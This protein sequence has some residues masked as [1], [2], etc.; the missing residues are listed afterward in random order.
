ME[1]WAG[2]YHS[3]PSVGHLRDWATQA[4]TPHMSDDW[5]ASGGAPRWRDLVLRDLARTHAPTAAWVDAQRLLSPMHDWHLGWRARVGHE[6]PWVMGAPRANDC[7]H[8]CMHAAV[9]DPLVARIFSSDF[10][11]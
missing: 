3:L 10:Y 9:W 7:L 4:C 1:P 5:K 8:F 11:L 6:R 2:E